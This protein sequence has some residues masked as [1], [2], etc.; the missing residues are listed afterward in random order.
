MIPGCYLCGL[1]VVEALALGSMMGAE[2]TTVT[3]AL[4][5]RR[6]I[7]VCAE[8]RDMFGALDADKLARIASWVTGRRFTA[9]ARKLG[10]GL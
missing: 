6:A 5:S 2:E 3:N 8:H 1:S 7:L 9:A 4:A 10:A